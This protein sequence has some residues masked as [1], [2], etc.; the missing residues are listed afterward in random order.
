MFERL[1][2]RIHDSY[3]VN[4]RSQLLWN[5]FARLTLLLF[6]NASLWKA[7]H[8]NMA[9]VMIKQ[10]LYSVLT[11]G[12]PNHNSS[13]LKTLLASCVRRLKPT[14]SIAM[15]MKMYRPKSS[16][17]LP[18]RKLARRHYQPRLPPHDHPAPTSTNCERSCWTPCRETTYRR[19]RHYARRQP[20]QV[21]V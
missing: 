9:A 6:H 4:S 14:S 10:L 1:A 20:M 5:D 17:N 7:T 3:Y 16:P 11:A 21:L 19:W 15:Q 13:W 18:K 2:L 8:S 12:R